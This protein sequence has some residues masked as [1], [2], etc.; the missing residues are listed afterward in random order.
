[1]SGDPVRTSYR[2]R[3]IDIR[4]SRVLQVIV[5][6]PVYFFFLSLY[7]ARILLFYIHCDS[8]TVRSIYQY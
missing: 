6:L 5:F 7:R 4:Q 3:Q 2:R 1:M 8:Y